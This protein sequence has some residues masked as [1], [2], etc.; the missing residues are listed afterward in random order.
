MVAPLVLDAVTGLPH[1]AGP[2][3]LSV[4]SAAAM[5]SRHRRTDDR[6]DAAYVAPVGALDEY[7]QRMDSKFVKELIARGDFEPRT[8][9]LTGAAGGFPRDFE[10]IYQEVL[11]EPR[12]PLNM[13]RLWQM[14]TRVPLGAR[15]HTVRRNLNSGDA[16]VTRTGGIDVPVVRGHRVEESFPVIYIVAGV[17]VNWFEMISNN[18]EGRNQFADDTRHAVRVIEE[19][20][21]R[22]AFNGDAPTQVFGFLNYPHL[23]K[24]VSPEVYTVGGSSPAAILGDLND[25]ANFAM[26]AS[27]GTFSPNRMATSIR[28]RNFLMQ[29]QFSAAS[30]VSIGEF[31]LKGHET[32]NTIEGVHELEGIGPNGE[33]G[34]AV[35]DDSIQST[36]F[37]MV[38]P[39]TAL[40][41][42]QIDSFRNQVVYVAAIGGTVMRDV[43]NNHLRF[44]VAA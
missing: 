5:A 1:A 23:A 14:D 33:D 8:D 43:G 44:A 18:F 27:G 7:R 21:N 30:D 39:P 4:V 22:I 9:A 28:L 20:M 38:Q 24:S 29:N 37:V 10:F 11:E 19:R 42:A 15:T 6:F 16:A 13:T 40:P 41:A 34:I 2:G 35:Y 25:T 31:F 32:I 36:T 3:V 12:R 26:E 17:E